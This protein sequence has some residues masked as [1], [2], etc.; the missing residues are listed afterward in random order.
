M[1]VERFVAIRGGT[2]ASVYV[3][4]ET[5]WQQLS[6][7]LSTDKIRSREY[8]RVVFSAMFIDIIAQ[9]AE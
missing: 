1:S 7:R 3:V 6:L 9:L 4:P 5:R 8:R 2:G